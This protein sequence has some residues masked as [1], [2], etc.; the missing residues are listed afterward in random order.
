MNQNKPCQVAECDG[1]YSDTI[2]E[3]VNRFIVR[4]DREKAYVTP[5]EYVLLQDKKGFHAVISTVCSKCGDDL[6]ARL[7]QFIRGN[8]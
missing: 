8:L 3:Y 5:E 6:N 4:G 7:V 2:T 1:S